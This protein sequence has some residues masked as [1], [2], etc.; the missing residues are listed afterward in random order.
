MRYNRKSVRVTASADDPAIST[1]DMKAYLRVDGTGDDALIAS[2]VAAATETVKQFT[3]RALLTETFV[4]K[5][6]GF[7]SP[8]GDDRLLALGP[9]VHTGSRH[10]LTGGGTSLDLPFTPLQSISSVVTYNRSNTAATYDAANY[11]VDLQSGR[12]YLNE[13]Q[14]WPS[15]LRDLDAVQITYVAGYGSGSIPEPILQAIRLYVS[16]MY[17]GTC[18]GL[19]HEAMRMLSPYRLLDELPW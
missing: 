19:T 6:D 11:G 8:H 3:R 7:T 17:D 1:A 16:G 13:G 4:F 15:D 5:C 2:H 10:Y 9:G 18:E 12:V 14:M